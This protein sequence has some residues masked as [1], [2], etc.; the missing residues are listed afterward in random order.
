MCQKKFIFCT[1]MGISFLFILLSNPFLRYPYDMIYH[2]IVIDNLYTQ[3]THPIQK[4]LGIWTNDI[5][6]MVPIEGVE[7][8]SFVNPRH[9]WHYV[10]AEFFY[11]LEIDSVHMLLRAKIIHMF[12]VII[13]LFSIYYFSKVIIRNIF[14]DINLFS[15]KWLSFWSALVWLSI[16]ATG[17]AA[18]HQVWMMWYSVNYQI[19]LPLFWYILALT[20][21]LFLEQTSWKVKIFFIFQI[22]LLSRFILQVHSM[23]F[24]YYLM[25][26]VVF[27]LVFIDK[28]YL[29]LKKYFY[30]IIPMIL[31]VVYFSKKYQPEQSAISKY[32]SLEKIPEL[33]AK[34]MREGATL[35]HG[36]NRASSTIN[37][38]IFIIGLLGGIFFFYILYIKY[39]KKKNT[40][41][42]IRAFIYVI[43]TSLF[44]LI[45]LYQFSGGL[46]AVITR[47][48][49]VNRLYY[50]SSLF[51][52]L[53]III[54]YVFQNYKLR[55]IHV[56]I[57]L[58]LMFVTV[59][60]KY[61]DIF[62]HN[63]YK[64]ILSLKNSFNER[65]VGFNLSQFQIDI[66]K[67]KIESD[68]RSNTAYKEIRYYARADIAFVIK[69]ILH[70]NVYWE[71]RRANPDYLKIY[72]QNR[73]NK[74]Y[75]Q[76][77]FETPKDFPIYRPYT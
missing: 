72:D 24:L 9:L 54:Y 30:I 14:K 64:N 50:S 53:P 67:Q 73:N 70:K 66:I 51:I 57:A 46:F 36:Y 71:G 52:L 65:K 37:E 15:L 38:L 63:Y 19:T 21:V 31:A 76:I 61:S 44:L 8:V 12:Q 16:F 40:F 4:V 68:E 45:P 7:P 56:F 74:D 58:S 35:V 3:L 59:F 18:Y 20:L 17:S 60:S 11:F 41:I 62:H 55:Y 69:Y 43:L 23:E 1:L 28:L 39:F 29:L 2:L 32:L 22:L 34:I 5:Y 27:G 77:L 6:I 48:N 75:Y 26:I 25:H 49:V 47:M 42:N 10:W 13:S 33:Y